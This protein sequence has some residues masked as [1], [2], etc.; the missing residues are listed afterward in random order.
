V[1][2]AIAGIDPAPKNT[3]IPDAVRVVKHRTPTAQ[4][5][6]LAA[7]RIRRF[8]FF[9]FFFGHIMLRFDQFQLKPTHRTPEGYLL[10]SASAARAGAL[11][12]RNPDGSSRVELVTEKELSR[13]DSLGSC[14]IKPVTDGHPKAGRVDSTNSR[15]LQ[16][17]FSLQNVQYADGYVNIEIV[18]T[19][20]DL[21][22]EIERGDKKEISLGYQLEKLDTTPGI[23]PRYG[24]YDAIQIGRM[25]NHVAV[26]EQGRAGPTVAIRT[27]GKDG[28]FDALSY[29]DDSCG[30]EYWHIHDPDLPMRV[31]ELDDETRCQW[32]EVY[33]LEYWKK[34]RRKD[35]PGE[36]DEAAQAAADKEVFGSQNDN[37]QDKNMPTKNENKTLADSIKNLKTAAESVAVSLAEQ[38]AD[39][40][41]EKEDEEGE[42]AMLEEIA[43]AMKGFIEQLDSMKAQ[44][45]AIQ[46]QYDEK[47]AQLDALLEE[48]RSTGDEDKEDM[49]E[50]KQNRGDSAPTSEEIEKDRLDWYNDRR[51]L[52]EAAQRYDSIEGADRLTNSELKRA[53]VKAH[54]G[55]A[56]ADAATD[57]EIQ[58][59][60]LAAQEIAKS[61]KDSYDDVSARVSQSRR[62]R[63][64][65]ETAQDRYNKRL[66]SGYRDDSSDTDK[67][68]RKLAEA[69]TG[70]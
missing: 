28:G 56:R 12:Y 62:D 41:E 50:D 24:R 45:D 33:Q 52:G 34:P 20:Q 47:N 27:D 31:K 10:C 9:L 36:R 2:W 64:G 26:V 22:D 35:K 37:R 30:G 7:P 32:I 66:L 40:D 21:A 18:V 63:A 46:G 23:H 43:K 8:L 59:L 38:R 70:K 42:N 58:G 13:K 68:A 3:H 44:A 15:E 53:I 1:Q 60:Y 17:G 19:D 49:D 25:C 39:E 57:S 11:L 61:R 16:R 48:F 51:D 6:R 67:I 54:F 65:A 29:R 69:L 5:K 4:V 55:E 14:A